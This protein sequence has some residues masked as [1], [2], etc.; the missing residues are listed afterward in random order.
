VELALPSAE[1]ALRQQ[2]RV[3]YDVHNG[4]LNAWLRKRLGCPHRAADVAQSTFLRMLAARTVVAELEQP[5]AWLSTTA[6]RIII[7]E[8]RRDRI[9]RSYLA[10]LA[11]LPEQ[12]HPSP[13]QVFAAVESMMRLCVALEFVSP[14]ARLAFVRHYVDGA[15]HAAIAAELGVSTRMVQKYLAQVLLRAHAAEAD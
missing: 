15:T 14:K 10:E 9:E 11:A 2:I 8:A 13:E 3:L 5:R 12:T 1:L 6:Q 4:W 7:D